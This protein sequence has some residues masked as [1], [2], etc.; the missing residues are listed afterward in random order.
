M[1]GVWPFRDKYQVQFFSRSVFHSLLLAWK[2]VLG[3]AAVLLGIIYPI[4]YVY[5]F[6]GA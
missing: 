4:I 5:H 1:Q 2:W 6:V 3:F